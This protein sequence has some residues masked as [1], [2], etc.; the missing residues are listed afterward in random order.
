[1]LTELQ[2]RNFRC[3]EALRVDFAP[4]FNFFIGAER[5]GEDVDSRSRVRAPAAAIAAQLDS[6]RR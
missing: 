3:F 1:M 4:G 5:A 6:S 2:L